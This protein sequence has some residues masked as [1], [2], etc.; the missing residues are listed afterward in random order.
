MEVNVNSVIDN[1]MTRR[2]IRSF[3]EQQIT[4][5]ELNTILTAGSYAPSGM[6][7]QS[8]K[9]TAIQDPKVLN[10]INETMRQT[11]LGIS[12]E[13]EAYAYYANYIKMAQ[14]LTSN[15]LYHAATYVLVSNQRENKNGFADSALAIG[16]MMLAAHSIGIGSCWLNQVPRLSEH[17][18]MRE[19][20]T[21]LEIPQDHTVYG[22]V[23]LGYPNGKERSAAPR[24][25]VIHII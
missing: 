25:D 2:S 9:F 12:P 6:A 19:L 7:L 24:K 23:V 15:F 20:L 16:N 18:L 21:E 17:E 5:D 13:S 1:I 8:W 3:K 14:D 10:K 11:L 22:S 4:R